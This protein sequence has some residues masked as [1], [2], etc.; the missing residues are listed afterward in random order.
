MAG[1]AQAGGFDAGSCHSCRCSREEAQRPTRARQVLCALTARVSHAY[2][3]L[4]GKHFVCFDH[5]G[6]LRVLITPKHKAGLGL[7]RQR[8]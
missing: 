4:Q 5:Q 7:Q 8:I 3:S 1:G 2:Q 6:E